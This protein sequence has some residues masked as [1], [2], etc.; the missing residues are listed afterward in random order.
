MHPPTYL[1]LSL[2]LPFSIL[3][4]AVASSSSAAQ[5]H[6]YQQPLPFI[7]CPTPHTPLSLNIHN[8]ANHTHSTDIDRISFTLTTNF[9]DLHTYCAADI[10]QGNGE[11]A[12]A[13]NGNKYNTSFGVTYTVAAGEYVYIDHLF[14]CIY[15]GHTNRMRRRVVEA[16]AWVN[17][18]LDE[19]PG[20]EG[21]GGRYA[22][23]LKL[24]LNSTGI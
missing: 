13:H 10:F 22:A 12:C 9:N 8:W 7:P 6:Q 21:G 19:V 24:Y 2:S 20:R 23:N 18:P 17:I 11:E 3:N 5:S 4:L 15:T 16:L 1:A 14:R